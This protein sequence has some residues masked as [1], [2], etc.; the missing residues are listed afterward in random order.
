[1][2]VFNDKERGKTYST[3]QLS[4][5]VSYPIRT[6]VPRECD[7]QANAERYRR[8]FPQAMQWHEL[9]LLGAAQITGSPVVMVL[10]LPAPGRSG[11]CKAGS[12]CRRFGAA[13]HGCHIR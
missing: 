6:E 11:F 8:E 4:V 3:F 7:L 2:E 9:T 12:R 1:M 13:A 10:M 5:S